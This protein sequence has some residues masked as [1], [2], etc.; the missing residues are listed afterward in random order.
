M[1]TVYAQ[2]TIAACIISV[3]LSA[4]PASRTR[5]QTLATIHH[6]GIYKLTSF[7]MHEYCMISVVYAAGMCLV[8]RGH[9]V[10]SWPSDLNRK[11]H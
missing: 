1:P 6:N 3:R 4:H 5:R 7:F 11:V 8:A 10:C 2:Q 9:P